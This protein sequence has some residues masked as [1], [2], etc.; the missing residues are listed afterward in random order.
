MFST[1]LP[2][3]RNKCEHSHTRILV[4]PCGFMAL[5]FLIAVTIKACDGWLVP[6][7][8]GC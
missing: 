8:R 3:V 5:A 6:I 4:Q 2:L 1:D 7:P